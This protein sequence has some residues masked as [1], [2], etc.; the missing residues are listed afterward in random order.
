MDF[1]KWWREMFTKII[2]AKEMIADRECQVHR[3]IKLQ[4]LVIIHKVLWLEGI[5]LE[6]NAPHLTRD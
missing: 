3:V 2:L 1:L 5:N 4:E 6:I